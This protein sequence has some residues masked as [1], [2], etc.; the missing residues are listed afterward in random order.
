M[1]DPRKNKRKIWQVQKKIK[2]ID[3]HCLLEE[4]LEGKNL[5]R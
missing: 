5:E 3:W 2:R 4:P 1:K